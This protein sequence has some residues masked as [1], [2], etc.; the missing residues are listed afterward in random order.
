MSLV[1]RALVGAIFA[2]SAVSALAQV[3]QEKTAAPA[4]VVPSDSNYSK[5]FRYQVQFADY[6]ALRRQQPTDV[7]FIGDSITEQFRWGPGNSVWKRFYEQRA[8]NFGKGGDRTQHVLW[9]LDN[10]DVS[11]IN[12]KVAVLMI[13]TNNQQDTPEEIAQGVKAVISKIQS[14]WPSAK[15]LLLSILPN[16]RQ[17]ERMAAADRLLP[18]LA[19]QKRVIY[20]DET[21]RFP[22]NGDNWTGLQGDKLHLTTQGYEGMAE[23]L[24]AALAK[25]IP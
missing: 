8:L 3:A 10:Q 6:T 9:R 16:G 4:T 18:A 13:G 22:R 24:N 1:R 19:D 23:D 15:I 2:V 25:L 7:I 14:K 11:G 20:L 17:T 5:D 12:P 21:H